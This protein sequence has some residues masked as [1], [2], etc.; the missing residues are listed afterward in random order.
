ME[1]TAT[2]KDGT[3][4]R[5]RPMTADDVDRSL[6]FFEA[7]PEEDSIF[8]RRPVKDRQAV[9]KRI[10]SM[11]EGRAQRIVALVGDEIVADGVLER[12]PDGWRTHVGE[13][14]LIVARPYQGKGL[15]RL[16]AFELYRLAN[17]AKVEDIIVKIMGPQTGV[18]KMF[19]HLGFHR[20]AELRDFVKDISGKRHHLVM[21][22]CRLQELW[23]RMEDE[24]TR[25]DWQHSHA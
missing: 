7:L 6:A 19:E 4:V 8:L 23:Q 17:L 1:Q 16:M 18:Q 20:E 25:S 13:I 10:K 22:R 24:M 2:L 12:D 21:M 3:E 5:I 11:E 14:R 9:L 15:G